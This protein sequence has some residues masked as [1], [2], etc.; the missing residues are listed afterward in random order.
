MCGPDDPK[1]TPPRHGRP[2]DLQ[3]QPDRCEAPPRSSGERPHMD[4]RAGRPEGHTAPPW[5]AARPSI[6]AR[7]LRSTA[8]Q[9]RRTPAHGCAGRTTRRP[10]RLAMDGRPTSNHSQIVAKHRPAAPANARTWMCGQDDPKT[11]PPRHGRPPHL[12]RGR[13]TPHHTTPHHTTPRRAAPRRADDAPWTFPAVGVRPFSRCRSQCPPP[14]P[15]EDPRVCAII[16][17]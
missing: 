8:P 9:L 6:A 14:T 16:P 11:T 10:H 7:S 5:T 12:R 4:V 3:S 1:T 17:Q 15:G 13:I 2:P